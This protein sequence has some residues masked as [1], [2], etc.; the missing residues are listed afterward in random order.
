MLSQML[1][2]GVL[3]PAFVAAL[4]VIVWRRLNRGRSSAELVAPAALAAGYL[5]GHAGVANGLQLL[6]SDVT[7]YAPHLALVAALWGI[8]AM[9]LRQPW[10]ATGDA[11]LAAAAAVL[12][13]RPLWG[14]QLVGMSGVLMVVFAGMAWLLTAR[15]LTAAQSALKLRWWAALVTVVMAVAAMVFAASG[16]LL[17]GRFMGAAAACCGALAAAVWLGG[18]ETQ[19]PVGGRVAAMLLWVCALLSFVYAELYVGSLCALLLVA[20]TF[21]LV[22]RATSNRTGASRIV[23]LTAVTLLP[24]ALSAGL[25]LTL[26]QPQAASAPGAAQGHGAENNGVG[27]AA[28]AKPNA[29]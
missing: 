19:L 12:L 16:S 21:A 28:E 14:R 5:M 25:A 13:L 15:A 3:L 2:T 11:L 6:P 23:T 22:A 24:L 26:G 9:R 29:D 10:V 17:I 18:I 7:H 8:A 27:S 20:P 4:V 1:F